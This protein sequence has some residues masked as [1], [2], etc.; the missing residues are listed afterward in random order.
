MMARLFALVCIAFLLHPAW[1]QSPVTHAMQLEDIAKLRRINSPAVSPDGQWVAY[2]VSSTDVKADEHVSHVWMV[3]WDG[4]QQAQVT[5]ASQSATSPRWRPK[6]DGL[7]FLAKGNGDGEGQQVWLVARSGGEARQLTHLH[8]GIEDY[9]WSPDGSELLLT[10]QDRTDRKDRE[11][12]KETG[13]KPIVITRYQFKADGEGYLTDQRN[14]F[15]LFDVDTAR[16]TRLIHEPDNAEEQAGEWSPDGRQIAF[17]SQRAQPDPEHTENADVFL[18]NAVLLNAKLNQAMTDSAPQQLTHFRG[19]V[20]GPLAWSPDGKT[21]AFRRARF[22]GYSS[23]TELEV[24]VVPAA[25]GSVRLLTEKLDRPAGAP[26]FVDDGKTLLTSVVDDRKVYAERIPLDGAAPARLTREA[27]VVETLEAR[28]GHAVVVWSTDTTFPEIYALEQD[29]T[30]RKLTH[31]NDVLLSTLHLVSAED[32]SARAVD[33]KQVHGL[34]TLPVDYQMGTKSPMLLYIHGGP[35]G[36]DAH[37]FDLSRQLFAAHGYAVLNVNYRGSNGRGFQYSRDIQADWGNKEVTDLMAM[38]DAAIATGNVD[39]KRLVVGGWSYGGILTDDLIAKTNRFKAA[40]A[41]A[42]RANLIGIYGVN[43]WVLQYDQELGQPWKNPALYIKLS[44]PFFHA[45]RI[46]T[47][48][49]FMGGDKDFNV[50]ISGSEQMYEALRSAGT[51]AELIV[52]PGQFHGFSRPSF[53]VDRYRR[54]FDW[55]DSHLSPRP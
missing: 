38:V 13:P 12:R 50:P 41:G 8:Q 25:G 20:E 4:T 28:A 53:I 21:I 9:R 49:L 22:P 26:F 45:D 18:V 7:S 23:Y 42:G 24:A 35:T 47:P 54:W 5:A 43:A 55:Y 29:G 32:I 48:T 51:P 52:Y 1:A 6:S 33:G 11:D 15:Y 19:T 2:A 37:E 44:Y 46:K 14:H 36:Q 31:Q 10:L 17:I 27:G 16:L 34:L 30:L 40:S 39:A 3:N